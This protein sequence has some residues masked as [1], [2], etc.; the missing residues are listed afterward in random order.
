M[1]I[2]DERELRD[3]VVMS[4]VIE[5]VEGGFASLARGE[6]R[7]PDVLYLDIQEFNGEVHGKGAHIQG[8]PYFVVKVAAGFYDNPSKDLP[9]AS[10]LMMVFDATTGHPAGLLADNGFLT[11][12]RTGAA[13]AVS[14]KYMARPELS[15]VAF[16]GAGLEARFQ[17]RA[18][19]QVRKLPAVEVWSRTTETANKFALEMG[20]ELSCKID[21][22]SELENA[23]RDADLVVTSTPSRRPLVHAD[24]LSRGVHVVAMGSDGPDKRE[25]ASDVL[26]RADILVADHLEHC[27]THG[28]IHHGVAD[29]SIRA[30]DVTA[31]LGDLVAELAVGRN[32]PDDITVCD[33]TGVGVQDAAVGGLAMERVQA[34]GLGRALSPSSDVEAV[35]P[36]LA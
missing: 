25:L 17:L 13:G 33:L 32:S 27:L 28:E 22:E 6:V 34:R 7:L 4:D 1:I 11:D 21:P 8:A 30:A 9:V 2:V 15:K 36:H 24:W 3:A 23:V 31:E 19:A 26:A 35:G 20:A 14:V 18:L 29:G 16:V 5:R 12:L 10:G